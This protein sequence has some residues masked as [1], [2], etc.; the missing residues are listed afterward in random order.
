MPPIEN[1]AIP[2]GNGAVPQ[3]EEFGS[4]E[5]TLADFYRL[6]NERFDRWDRKLDEISDEMRVISQHVSS[7]EQDAR[8]PRF[9]MEADEQADTKTRERTEGAATNVFYQLR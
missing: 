6:L 2:E 8:Q 5:P 9:A 3:Q 4:G 7:L 1:K